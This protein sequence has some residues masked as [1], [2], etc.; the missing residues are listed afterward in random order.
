M[1]RPNDDQD[2][3]GKINQDLT[4]PADRIVSETTEISDIE[5][6]AKIQ[7]KIRELEKD[8]ATKNQ[9]LEALKLSIQED[10]RS[11]NSIQNQI[12]L[13]QKELAIA[14]V[15]N[16]TSKVRRLEKQV[17]EQE[18]L[19]KDNENAPK[20][21]LDIRQIEDFENEIKN[22]QDEINRLKPLTVQE[23]AKGF[24]INR[25]NDLEKL[26]GVGLGTRLDK[27]KNNLLVPHTVEEK[28]LSSLTKEQESL[29]EQTIR[30]KALM[31]RFDNSEKNEKLKAEI[32]DLEAQI[33][34]DKS[35]YL[36]EL[37]AS[38]KQ[39]LVN[40]ERSKLIQLP[41]LQLKLDNTKN[42]EIQL[43]GRINKLTLIVE[44]QKQVALAAKKESTIKEPLL[45]SPS[46]N[47]VSQKDKIAAYDKNKDKVVGKIK[48]GDFQNLQDHLT[49]N[50]AAPGRPIDSKPSIPTPPFQAANSKQQLQATQTLNEIAEL[51]KVSTVNLKAIELG[52]AIFRSNVISAKATDLSRRKFDQKQ[53]FKLE[54]KNVDKVANNTRN[55]QMNDA[56]QT[57]VDDEKIPRK[58]ARDALYYKNNEAMNK[59]TAKLNDQRDTSDENLRVV[60]ADDY[61]SFSNKG[62]IIE[63]NQYTSIVKLDAIEL[64]STT[65]KSNIV[66][67]K[68]IES[69]QKQERKPEDVDTSSEVT[70][71]IRSQVIQKQQ[72]LLKQWVS[73][74]DSEAKALKDL[75][76][77]GFMQFLEG[78]KSEVN[79]AL[80]NSDFKKQIRDIEVKGF[81][82]IIT[83][84]DP[85][86]LSNISWS[87]NDN[88]QNIKDTPIIKDGVTLCTLKEETVFTNVGII[89]SSGENIQITSYRN[90]NFQTKLNSNNGPLDIMMALKSA[91]GKNISQGKA[92][93]FSAHYDSLGNLIDVA[94]PQPVKFSGNGKDATCYI[95]MA[96]EI[97]TLPVTKGKYKEM[98]EAVKEKGKAIN[99]DKGSS[100]SLAE[101][102]V[103][104]SGIEI[105]TNPT[106]AK[107]KGSL[108]PSSLTT[109]RKLS[110]KSHRSI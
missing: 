67:S 57:F 35:R 107:I 70:K 7:E 106:D 79:A 51:T 86:S 42:Q 47:Q 46:N 31:D 109:P 41:A 49:N 62:E 32:K 3:N 52:A 1:V 8:L 64:K 94:S 104:D 12:D 29:K 54:K 110:E 44:E 53:E 96:G 10:L 95:E 82:D 56:A 2:K 76:K 14:K 9:T 103:V 81:R 20:Q 101:K 33:V 75:D 30:T 36:K 38:T 72:D 17:K 61:I 40:S 69:V 16:E 87:Q 97:Y 89:N 23:K 60:R 77:Q 19:F 27:L 63:P 45:Q 90:I 88:K 108:K 4:E 100:K 92:L 66:S 24:D 65:L 68:T 26:L 84:A 73:R 21:H 28:E 59:V 58:N 22:L 37:L 11:K 93:Y 25:K 71:N 55:Q 105:K 99:L 85:S 102:L 48:L 50:F 34:N 6:K 18:K 80:E 13:F 83:K 98:M 91:D 43:A 5:N 15:M 78:H 74:N 39:E